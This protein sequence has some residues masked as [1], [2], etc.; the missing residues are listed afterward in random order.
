MK[1]LYVIAIAEFLILFISS[2]GNNSS[3]KST[4]SAPVTESGEAIYKRTCITCHQAGGEGIQ[5]TY[6]PLAKSDFL[7]DKD[8]TIEQV[9]KGHMG[10]MI[11]N[12]VKYNNVMPP[13]Q[14]SD[15]EI[16]AVLNYVNS[17]FGNSGAQIATAD[18]KA[19]RAKM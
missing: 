14:L 15:D 8:K 3:P 13:Q 9:I 5:G 11:V 6:P 18:V 10:E 7:A 2:C 17:S 4:S 16:V 12:G 19:V 1:K